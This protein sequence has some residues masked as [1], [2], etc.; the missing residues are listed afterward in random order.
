M[1]SFSVHNSSV[2]RLH[3][4]SCVFDPPTRSE[5]SCDS[6]SRVLRCSSVMPLFASPNHQ[7]PTMY[8]VAVS[9]EYMTLSRF[10]KDQ[11]QYRCTNSSST[12]QVVIKLEVLEAHRSRACNNSQGDNGDSYAKEGERL[13]RERIS[14]L[15]CGLRFTA[16]EEK[17]QDQVCDMAPMATTLMSNSSVPSEKSMNTATDRPFARQQGFAM[18]P[19]AIGRE[20]ELPRLFL[21][22]SCAE[23]EAELSRRCSHVHGEWRQ[24]L[25]TSVHR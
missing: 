1:H 20:V 5:Y 24:T 13:S 17:D 2:Y 18:A 19:H 6:V 7:A 14:H 4:T 11:C 21:F 10:S 8:A 15:A 3:P 12:H 16:I 23:T 25:C 22:T 9:R